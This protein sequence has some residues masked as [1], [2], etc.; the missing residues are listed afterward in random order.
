MDDPAQA[1]PARKAASEPR[2][3]AA[4]DDEEVLATPAAAQD[5][6]EVFAA[7]AANAG[8]PTANDGFDMDVVAAQALHLMGQQVGADDENAL[9][10]TP[11]NRN[12]LP[13]TE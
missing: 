7:E 8:L 12:V 4:Q 6:T 2:K 9:P 5:L 13:R 1:T 11:L 3:R 10:V